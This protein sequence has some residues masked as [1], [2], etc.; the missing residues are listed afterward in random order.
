MGTIVE[1]KRKNG[2][3]AFM[4]KIII[5]RGGVV[6][7]RKTETFDRRPAARAWVAIQEHDLSKPGALE[8][9]SAP[10]H[11]LGDAIRKFKED[12]KKAI[13]RTKLQVLNYILKMPIA[14]MACE[15][16]G[17]KQLI[18]FCSTLAKD[19]KPATVATYLSGLSG[20][21]RLAWAAWGMSLDREAMATTFIVARELGLIDRPESR[22]RR[23]TLDELHRVLT[24]FST[25]AE[26]AMPMVD[27]VIFAIFSARRQ[28]EITRI[29]WADLDEVGSR[30]LVR[31][32]KNP[33]D[34]KGNHVWCDLPPQA[35][36]IIQAQPRTDDRIFPYN[37]RSVGWTFADAC[38]MLG[39]DDL[40]FHD[41]RHEAV[42]RLFE[43]GWTIP[44]VATVSAHR[45]W[46]NLQRYTHV[47]QTGD[48]YDGW[49]WLD[50]F[51]NPVP[52][53][54][55]EAA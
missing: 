35:L 52:R 14:D 26:L 8:R 51:T 21:F 15:K 25:R 28:A 20:V 54:Q 16:I 5:R 37:S 42:S 43:M 6:V 30:V 18:D 47:R 27:I 3:T 39:I 13:G 22:E 34:T 38:R 4:A 17:S 32:M 23:P 45:S 44:R 55:E 9:A 2:T 48:K 41:L 19:R 12:S 46:Q 7:Y 1:R 40:R 11:T 50:V 31:D 53:D 24:W 36:Q 29:R 10:S 49:K 33:G